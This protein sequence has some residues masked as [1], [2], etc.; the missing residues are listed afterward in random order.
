MNELIRRILPEVRKIWFIPVMVLLG[1]VLM[2]YQNDRTEAIPVAATTADDQYI[3]ETEERIEQM[4]RNIK[5][6]GYC[7]V[8]I[9]LASGSKKEYVR[10]DGN[11][12]VISDNE[13]NQSAVV[14]KDIAPEI[15]GVTVLS[16]GAENIA[17]QKDIIHSVS[18]VLGIGTNKVCVI[19]SDR[20]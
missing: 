16:S 11:V 5:G 3:T 7:D 9:T 17:I 19:L 12:L 8:T 6:A 4:L 20:E 14:S 10:E 13:G 18:T 1:I 15:A 2:V